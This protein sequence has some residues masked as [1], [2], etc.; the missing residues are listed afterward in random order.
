VPELTFATRGA[1]GPW[2]T[3]RTGSIADLL[4]AIPYFVM[5]EIPP[6]VLMNDRLVRGG[7]DAGMS[8]GCI[9]KPLE[10]EEG[11][12]DALVEDLQR[13][14]PALRVF[15]VPDSVRTNQAWFEH[16]HRRLPDHIRDAEETTP[17]LATAYERWHD[18]LPVADL[19]QGYLRAIDPD[20]RHPAEGD[21]ELPRELVAGVRR[22]AEEVERWDASHGEARSSRATQLRMRASRAATRD[23]VDRLGLPRWPFDRFRLKSG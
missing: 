9:W 15:E 2:L 16:R 13:R 7:Y 5:H 3:P 6:L 20:W 4:R 22:H 10:L 21:F 12:F 17:D 19:Y 18:E 8:G 23:L 1:I 11:E 14:E